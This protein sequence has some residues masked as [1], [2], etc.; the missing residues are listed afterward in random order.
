MDQKSRAVAEIITECLA[1]TSQ[2]LRK[3]VPS[4]LEGFSK[5]GGYD[6]V[7]LAQNCL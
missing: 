5:R 3:S 4:S 1:N 6:R 2:R 7:L